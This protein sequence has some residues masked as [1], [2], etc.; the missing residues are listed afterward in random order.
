MLIADFITDGVLVVD[1][2]MTKE[3]YEKM[4]IE[5]EEQE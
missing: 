2:I 3:E 1:K 5:K 4:A